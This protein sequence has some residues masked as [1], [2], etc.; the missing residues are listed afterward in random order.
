MELTELPSSP[1]VC[2]QPPLQPRLLQPSFPACGWLQGASVASR[3]PL[4]QPQPLE[5]VSEAEPSKRV[6]PNLSRLLAA[7][8]RGQPPQRLTSL[9]TW[10]HP[11]QDWEGTS[12]RA[13]PLY[14][15]MKNEVPVPA[16]LQIS[17]L[18]STHGNNEAIGTSLA[19]QWLRLHS[20]G[21]RHWFDLWSGN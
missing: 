21:S 8:L 6:V 19:V 17:V 9:P 12:H 13:G 7:P 20:Q 3:C 10:S 5:F 15:T 18:C 4:Y 1:G 16:P 14:G 2:N 11:P